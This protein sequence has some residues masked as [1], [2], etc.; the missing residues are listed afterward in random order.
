M[1]ETVEL[2]ATVKDVVR[3]LRVLHRVL[4]GYVQSGYERDHGPVGSPGQLLHLAMH[5]PAFGWLHALSELMVDIDELL[6]GEILTATDAA[7]VRHEIEHLLARSENEPND[8][9]ARYVEVLQRDPDLVMV[10][11]KVR[12][13]IGELPPT[14]PANIEDVRNARPQWS[15]RRLRRRADH[16]PVH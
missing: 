5:D 8:F 1:S 16:G 10:H 12:Q 13:A 9:A 6:D 15:V 14:E 3:E 7:A 2:R 11:S 4:L